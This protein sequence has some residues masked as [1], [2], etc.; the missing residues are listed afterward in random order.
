MIVRVRV[1]VMVRVFVVVGLGGGVQVGRWV[2][3]AVGDARTVSSSG[4]GELST[5]GVLSSGSEGWLA[6]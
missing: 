6:R 5:V 2:V 4:D 1:G 3:S